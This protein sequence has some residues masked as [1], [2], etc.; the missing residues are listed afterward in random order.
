MIKKMLDELNCFLSKITEKIQANVIIAKEKELGVSFPKG[1]NEFYEY[2][3]NDKNILNAYYLFRNIEDIS[4]EEEALVF[5]CTDQGIAKLGITLEKLNSKYQ[6]VSI[7]PDFDPNWYSEGAL[8]PESFFFNIAAW[9]ILNLMY[10]QARI[11]IKE[12]KFRKLC[13]KEFLYFNTDEKYKNGYK[14][15]ACRRKKVLGCYIIE[16]EEFYF[17]AVEDNELHELEKEL[18]IEL[19]WL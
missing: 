12:D 16:S 14:I 2:Y 7:Y 15:I 8:Y 19:D 9:Q 1:M 3:G 5:G 17:G 13:Q 4:I 10:A 18:K 6:S 11:E